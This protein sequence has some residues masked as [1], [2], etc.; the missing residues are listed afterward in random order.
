[1]PLHVLVGPD[2]A[3]LADQAADLVGPRPHRVDL[4]ADGGTGLVDLLSAGSLFGGQRRIHAAPLSA[5]TPRAA[6]GLAAVAGDDVVVLTDDRDPPTAVLRCLDGAQV[7]RFPLPTVKDASARVRSLLDAHGVQADRDAV[8]L[9]VRQ[10]PTHW[11]RVHRAVATVADLDLG[12]MT[13]HLAATLVG[14]PDQG[15]LPWDVAGAL[16]SGDLARAL[17][18]AWA[19]GPIPTVAYLL[20]RTQQ[21]GLVIDGEDAAP[22][23]A[24]RLATRLGPQGVVQSLDL[25][26]RA[27]RDVKVEPDPDARLAVLLVHLSRLWGPAA[28]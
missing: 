22:R 19:A 25:L 23:S 17:A 5:L 9:L 13:G 7:T 4:T 28:T 14:A 3:T 15:G 2:T 6:T 12:P 21:A 24:A 1:M 27:D 8:Q 16:E 11:G 26:V 18:L 20:R 10:A